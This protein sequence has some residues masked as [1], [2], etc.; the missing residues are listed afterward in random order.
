VIGQNK[1]LIYTSLTLN[2][3]TSV[4]II[5]PFQSDLIMKK[6]LITGILVA[7]VAFAVYCIFGIWCIRSSSS[8]TAAIGYIF[9]PFE[10]FITAIP[11][12]VIGFCAHY[13]VVKLRRSARSGYIFATIAAAL[14]A[15]F[16]G[17]N[18]NNLALMVA[19]NS[20]RTMPQSQHEAFLKDSYWRTNKYVL[21]ALL[22]S[23]SLSA[24][25]LYQIATI[26]SS[27]LHQRMWA[28]PPIMGENTKGLAVM[29]LVV[30]H[31]NVDERTLIELAKSSDH[32]V[33]GDVASNPKTPVEIL[34]QFYN[35]T[36]RDYLIDWG[37]AWNPN[38][39]EDILCELAKSPD[40]YTSRPA[41][42]NLDNARK[43]LEK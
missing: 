41:A 23:P 38:T 7:I 2:K 11:F 42:R 3:T 43:D 39:P 40:E 13:A 14:T 20:A 32:Y 21:G 15:Y 26:P 33:L 1:N 34:Q 28:M 9:L 19:V 24:E 18:V 10:A 35:M 25:S 17:I 16:I 6:P 30:G 29:R 22:E 5:Y 37:L 36:D 12:F 27:D 8:S 31:P 4:A